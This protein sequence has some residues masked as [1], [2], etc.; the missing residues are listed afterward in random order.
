MLSLEEF[1]DEVGSPRL[2]RGDYYTV[3]GF[4]VTQIGRIPRVSESIEWDGM[5]FEVVD[6]DGHRVDKILVSSRRGS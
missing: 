3:A 4:L 6:L 1:E 2:P 5:T